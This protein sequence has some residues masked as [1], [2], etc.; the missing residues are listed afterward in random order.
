MANPWF[1]MY[2]EIIYNPKVQV[3]PEAL[4]WRYV[5]LLCLHC[6]GQYEV[7]PS[8]EIALALRIDED[9]WLKTRDIFIKRRLL[10]ADGSIENWESRQYISDLK[11]PTAAERMQ[12][13]R[14]K[15]RLE[16]ERNATV[17]LR[18]PE[19][20]TDTDIKPPVIPQQAGGL[21]PAGDASA[22]PRKKREATTFPK[23]I[24]SVRAAGEKP[25]ADY[26][27]L[28]QYMQTVG[29]PEDF[30]GLAWQ[31]FK[32]RYTTD[33]KGKR[34]RYADW[35][36]T[37]LNAVKGNWFKLWYLDADSSWQLTTVGKQAD[38]AAAAEVPA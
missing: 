26:L 20:D 36:A 23:W 24:E 19:S 34:K 2:S 18:P 14:A 16:K 32:D 9:E 21:P 28:R 3:L 27:A 15:K 35:R 1:R 25:V 12:R 7:T 37:F 38:L 6:N 31:S 4:R 11:D 13:Y 10:A 29:L 17:T 5:A 33:E 8:D 30:V 22:A